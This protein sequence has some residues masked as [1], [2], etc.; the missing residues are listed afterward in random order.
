MKTNREARAE[1]TQREHQTTRSEA[2]SNLAGIGAARSPLGV[3]LPQ[4]AIDRSPRMVAQR[5]AMHAAFGN[6]AKRQPVG[7]HD[8]P[9]QQGLFEGTTVQRLYEPSTCSDG[10]AAAA[11]PANGAGIPSQL[12]AGIESLSGMDLSDVRVHR[13][14]GEPAQLQALAFA[15][16]NDIHL[17]PGHEQHLPHEA[18][19]VVQQRQGRVSETA[20]LAG[21]GINNEE[22]LER[23]ADL[24][25]SQAAL[26]GAQIAAG[27]RQY[28]RANAPARKHLVGAVSHARHAPPIG[29]A[30][31]AKLKVGDIDYGQ[32]AGGEDGMS[33]LEA[34]GAAWDQMLTYLRQKITEAEENSPEQQELEALVA[35]IESEELQYY[36]QFSKWIDDRPHAEKG[37][38]KHPVFGR[39]QQNREY[40]N[41][42]EVAKAVTGWVDAKPLRKKEK[43]LAQQIYENPVEDAV[44]NSLVQKVRLKVESLKVTHPVRYL[45]IVRELE[46]TVTAVRTLQGHVKQDA[47]RYGHYEK[48][49]EKA[50]DEFQAPA[51]KVK[52]ANKLQILDNPAAYSMRD[53]IVLLHD[54]TEYFGKH[55]PWNPVTAG[56]GLIPVDNEH[57]ALVTTSI[58]AEGERVESESAMTKDKDKNKLA[59]GMGKTTASRDEKAPST[60]LARQLNL[61]VWAGQSMTTVR[62]LNMAQWAGGQVH[63]MNALA[64]GIFAFW[65]L[66]YN[67]TSDFAYHTLHEVMDMAKNFGVTYKMHPQEGMNLELMNEAFI[68][69]AVA[70]LVLAMT[71][72]YASLASQIAKNNW[73]NQEFKQKAQSN[74]QVLKL[75]MEQV[76]GWWVNFDFGGDPTECTQ[77]LTKVM[78]GL[79]LMQLDIS[80]LDNFVK[81]KSSTVAVGFWD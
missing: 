1:I 16:G 45:E 51:L 11:L 7:R 78:Q 81:L 62:M 63:E 26:Q 52:Y 3:S 13:N 14:S 43:E 2:A 65:R 36:V 59:R 31:Q 67:H 61:P 50:A 79:N 37:Y 54:I 35:K 33:V 80:S 27:K 71:T 6:A 74:L 15:Q 69:P 17:G 19:H 42:I 66:E 72:G 12:K 44:L 60:K 73:Q 18:W 39:K 38:G 56:Q 68:R 5:L 9:S 49:M 47:T 4:A 55:Q 20:H 32:T 29:T 24:M 40:D 76:N 23:E 28:V 58:N 8:E 75:R 22:G 70:K 21:V 30:I 77:G 34:A 46:N 41:W 48:E 53:K 57:D 10:E 64:Q 25:G